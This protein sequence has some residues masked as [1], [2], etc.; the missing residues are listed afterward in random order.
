MTTATLHAENGGVFEV[1]R[2]LPRPGG[3]V[4]LIV[5]Y[6]RRGRLATYSAYRR[7]IDGGW[8]SLHGAWTDYEQALTEAPRTDRYAPLVYDPLVRFLSDAIAGVYG[9]PVGEGPDIGIEAELDYQR[10]KD[11]DTPNEE[12]DDN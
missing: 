7:E 2:I 5:T 3:A 9:T 11:D 8:K 12:G 6:R 1:R 10:S 4:D